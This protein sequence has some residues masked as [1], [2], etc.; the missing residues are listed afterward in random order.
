MDTILGILSGESYSSIR[1][2]ADL[3]VCVKYTNNHHGRPRSYQSKP[4]LRLTISYYKLE[5]IRV[6]RQDQN[7]VVL[8]VV[9]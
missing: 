6:L 3:S 8:V 9:V 1:A 4:L 7:H 5:K 2:L